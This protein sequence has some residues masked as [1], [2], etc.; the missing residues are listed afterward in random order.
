MLFASPSRGSRTG[1]F[2]LD[3][4]N[5]IATGNHGRFVM[6]DV[7]GPLERMGF[8]LITQ[9]FIVKLGKAVLYVAAGDGNVTPTE[10]AACLEAMRRYGAAAAALEEIR[11][12]DAKRAKLDEVVTAELRPLA[13]FILHEAISVARVDGFGA[14][15]REAAFQAAR[16]LGVPTGVV[17]AIEG[18]LSI[19]ET[20]K[21]ARHGLIGLPS[22]PPPGPN[23]VEQGAETR[24][25][26]MGMGGPVPKQLGAKIGKAILTIAGSDGHL[27]EREMGW[28]LGMARALGAPDDVI[29]DYQKF[30]YHSA[31]LSDWFDEETRPFGRLILHDAI[32]VARSD[33]FGERERAAA[34]RA[35]GLLGL[36][37]SLVQ[38]IEGFLLVEDGVRAARMRVLSP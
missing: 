21:V 34:V 11:T 9:Q 4:R 38:A 33:G 17:T 1:A 6:E 23:P 37:T 29:E 30:D 35:A 20:L 27:S 3:N 22:A 7:V 18:I 19:E 26:E 14:K 24:A 28:F 15:E 36:D 25:K 31:R 5:A 16:A 13:R 32:R 2:V 12:F 8:P 10:R